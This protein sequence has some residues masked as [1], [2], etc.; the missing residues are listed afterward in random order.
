V[1][2]RDSSALLIDVINMRKKMRS[3]MLIAPN[4]DCFD[5]KQGEGG[6]VDIEFMVQYHILANARTY[7]GL[8]LYSDNIRQLEALSLVG[9]L[10]DADADALK[11]AYVRYRSLN[12]EAILAGRAGLI[13]A[14]LVRDERRTV[15]RL[16]AQW[17][18]YS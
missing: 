7:P 8:A 1:R 4:I 9:C 12:H 10:S 3:Q 11:A 17:M 13:A 15:N 18:K 16:W 5:L 14:E 2:T 6:I